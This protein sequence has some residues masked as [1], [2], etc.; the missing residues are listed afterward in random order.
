MSFYLFKKGLGK[1]RIML[2]LAATLLLV[3][4][5][6]I[7]NYLFSQEYPPIRWETE[8]HDFGSMT[9]GV[10]YTFEFRFTNVGTE[11]LKLDN[12]KTKCDCILPH[13][14]NTIVE[15]NGQGSVFIAMTLEKSGIFKKGILVGFRDYRKYNKI[16]VW[17]HSKDIPKDLIVSKTGEKE[18]IDTPSGDYGQQESAQPPHM[19]NNKD[20]SNDVPGDPFRIKPREK[21][22]VKPL[23]DMS[24]HEDNA[25]STEYNFMT[26]R[27][28]QMI[29]EINL[30]RS[31]P[32]G[33]IQYV[34]EYISFLEKEVV[35][36]S[37]MAEFYKEEIETASE[38][39]DELKRTEPLSILRPHEGVHDAAKQHGVDM[40]KMGKIEHVGS[41][42]S[43]PWDRI[44]KAAPDLSD[45]NENL[46]GGPAQIRQAVMILLVDTG[47]QGRGHR[48]TLLN[49]TW[50]FVACYE[51]GTIEDMPYCWVQ[52]FGKK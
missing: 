47:I 29:D 16:E 26:K 37:G 12:V 14:S 40:V 13:W 51:V 18:K 6:F 33:Y 9:K 5:G 46:V 34:E 24:N 27:E 31:N 17:G 1:E 23:P 39:I 8:I 3:T 42:N 7:N 19:R 22:E 4:V 36:G 25:P 2:R 38:L 45:G 11:P 48:K 32:V 30:V 28:K 15:P 41:D 44:I 20:I 43:Y 50:N 35:N 49:P 10:P 52:N 21:N